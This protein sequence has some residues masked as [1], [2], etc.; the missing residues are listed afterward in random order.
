MV[1]LLETLAIGATAAVML[2]TVGAALPVRLGFRLVLG[3]L[4][5]AWI[6]LVA[7]L[8]AGGALANPAAVPV[9]FAIPLVSATV[10][11]AASARVRAALLALPVAL[12]V[13]L[14]VLRVLGIGFLVLAASA[15]MGGPFPYFA[16]IGDILTGLLAIGVAGIAARNGAND[17]RVL[18]WNALGM[19]DLIVAT[20]LGTI[21][22]PGSPLQVIHAGAGSAPIATLPWTLIP[23]ALVPA[24]LIGHAVVFAQARAQERRAAGSGRTRRSVQTQNPNAATIVT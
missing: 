7:S 6:A 17:R 21:S 10:L 12:I 18:A 3:A 20:T 5:G 23:L 16:G 11:C 8:A 22:A 19:L 2:T 14:N 1:D 24:Y 4:G 9:L 13:R 15:R